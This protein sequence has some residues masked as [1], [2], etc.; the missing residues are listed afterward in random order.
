MKIKLRIPS[1]K[2]GIHNFTFTNYIMIESS[3]DITRFLPINSGDKSISDYIQYHTEHLD[4]SIEHGIETGVFFHVHILYMVFVYFQ[5]LRISQIKTQE[6][7][8]SWILS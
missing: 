5:L 1:K 2:F 8:Y 7:K 6:F 3:L 4:K